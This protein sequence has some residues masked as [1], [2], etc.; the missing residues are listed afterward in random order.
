MNIEWKNN[1]KQY[2]SGGKNLFLGKYCVA[3]VGWDGANW[4]D[5]KWIVYLDLPGLKSPLE[6]Q[7]KRIED[8]KA[9]AEQAVETWIEGST[10]RL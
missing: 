8:A 1:E 5:E 6:K 3:S 4:T 2:S 10:I 7:Y 9:R